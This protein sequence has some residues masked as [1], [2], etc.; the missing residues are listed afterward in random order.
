VD[1]PR[2]PHAVGH[3]RD[4][5]R[6]QLGGH[7]APGDRD[8]LT[9]E[10]PFE[11]VERQV[12]AELAGD[13]IS[14]EPRASQAPVDRLRRPRRGRDLRVDRRGLAALAGVGVADVAQHLER[15]RQVLELLDSLLPDVTKP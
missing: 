2:P 14:Q 12:V 9:L 4:Q 11:P 8:V 6:D 7:R 3:E 5:R 15:R 10:D 1:H 13:H